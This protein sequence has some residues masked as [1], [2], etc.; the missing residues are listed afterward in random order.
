MALLEVARI[1]AFVMLDTPAAHYLVTR[2]LVGSVRIEHCFEE[3]VIYIGF[4]PNS[5]Q[6]TLVSALVEIYHRERRRMEGTAGLRALETKYTIRIPE[7][8][9]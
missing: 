4:T 9:F 6:A 7:A 1:D 8:L 3:Q 5:G 2:D